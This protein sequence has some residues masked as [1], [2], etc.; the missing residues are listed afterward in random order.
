M[1]LYSGAALEKANLTYS[2]DDWATVELI[3]MTISNRTCNITIPGQKASATVQYRVA[4]DDVIKNHLESTG[5]YSVKTQPTLDIYLLKDKVLLGQNLTITGT[6]SSN[7]NYSM[8]SIQF[9]S[10]NATVSGLLLLT[11]LN[12]RR[13]GDVM[14]ISCFLL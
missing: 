13:L 3:P 11:R 8:I 4:A 2:V 7:D 14:G 12:L 5:N 1:P 10:A 6:L 9:F